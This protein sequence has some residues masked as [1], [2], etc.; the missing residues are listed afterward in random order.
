[1]QEVKQ[2]KGPGKQREGAGIS[3]GVR[4]GQK[5]GSHRGLITQINLR[6]F[7]VKEGRK[8]APA[9]W[10]KKSPVT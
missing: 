1:M 8:R 6:G 5:E 2:A 10:T 4:V 3:P 7:P 9:F